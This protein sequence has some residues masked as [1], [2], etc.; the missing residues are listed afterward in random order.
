M[1]SKYH[2]FSSYNYYSVSRFFEWR[3]FISFV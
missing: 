3:H 1:T 2:N